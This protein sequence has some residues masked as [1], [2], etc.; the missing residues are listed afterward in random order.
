MRSGRGDGGRHFYFRRPFAP[1]SVKG[2]DCIDLKT[3]TG[4]CVA[5]PSLHPD[6]GLPYRWEGTDP[7]L[8]PHW[9]QQDSWL[10]R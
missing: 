5:P 9:L 4:Y 1:L 6:T 8:M 10:P 7:V 2:L 3:N